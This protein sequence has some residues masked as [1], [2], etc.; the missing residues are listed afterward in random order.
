MHDDPDPHKNQSQLEILERDS[1]LADSNQ[2]F[3][4]DVIA[5]N[6]EIQNTRHI[7]WDLA[8]TNRAIALAILGG[9][10]HPAPETVKRLASLLSFETTRSNW[11]P[12]ALN[13]PIMTALGRMGTDAK[14]ALPTLLKLPQDQIGVAQ[15]IQRISGAP[16]VPD[17]VSVGSSRFIQWH[18]YL[19][20]VGDYHIYLARDQKSWDKFWTENSGDFPSPAVDFSKFSVLVYFAGTSNSLMGLEFTGFE[21]STSSATATIFTH[22]SDA[23]DLYATFPFLMVQIPRTTVPLIVNA[24]VQTF[25]FL[26][27]KQIARFEP[28]EPH[29][30]IH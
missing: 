23:I 28:E 10:R 25:G 19:S 24:K 26:G 14:S 6:F 12:S 13:F 2:K 17:T 9:V 22:Y 3:L 1:A 20:K 29:N 27:E 4:L 18:G 30:A 15:T 16:P 7:S 5:R 21:Q 8:G 11:S